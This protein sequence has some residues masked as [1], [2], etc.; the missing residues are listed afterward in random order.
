M[1]TILRLLATAGFVFAI[2]VGMLTLDV[3]R[4][5]DFV[6]PRTTV[7]D[8]SLGGMTKI[9][10]RAALKQRWEV[11]SQTPITLVARG[12]VQTFTLSELGVLFDDGALLE[13]IPSS[14]RVSTLN[15][16]VKG[17]FGRRYL[18]IVG[19]SRT[20][21]TELIYKKFPTIPE[22]KNA[23]VKLTK[24][25]L[26]A[27]DGVTGMKPV[28]EPL[29]R[30]LEK[31]I[32]FFEASPLIIKF[33][34][35]EPDISA[36]DLHE[37]LPAIQKHL[38]QKI[39]FTFEKQTVNLDLSKH[40]DWI[41]F[42][43]R[44]NRDTPSLANVT[45]S[46][47]VPFLMYVD[48]HEFNLFVD[49]KLAQVVDQKPEDVRIWKESNVYKV[50][51]RG[52][53]GRAV[54]RDML[55][56]KISQLLNNGGLET[57]EVPTVVVAAKVDITPELQDLGI[58]ELVAVGFTRYDGSPANRQHN[59]STGVAKYNGIFIPQGVE[60]S[61]DENIGPVDG[62]HG[63]LKEL[64]I[65]PEGTV[66]EFGGGLCQVSTTLYRAALYAGLPISKRSPH[67]Y[68]VGYYAQV[69]GHG[70]DA[71]VYPP[72]VDLKF[73]NDTP[74]PLLIQSY[75]EGTSAYFKL[76]GTKDNREVVMDGPY[77]SNQRSAPSAPV[78]V[79]DKNLK[80]GQRKQVEKAH[81]G[82]DALWYRTITK[83]PQVVKEEIKSHYKAVPNKFLVG[84]ADVAAKP[85]GDVNPFE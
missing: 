74:G 48:P 19:I 63:F 59:V 82:F 45:L 57:I 30:E 10:A 8:V 41:R 37:Y 46:N 55:H 33:N 64:V 3:Y 44:E 85:D 26:Q 50:E 1:D 27:V 72:N 53:D 83:G 49:Q 52:A 14:D 35:R 54:N 4:K 65:K 21:I 73:I 25:G 36:E 40:P 70:L 29:A 20:Q 32:A 38:D 71:T 12:E 47:D 84:G 24:N 17:L 60:F 9:Q 66:P 62:E 76:Y 78:E 18:P 5:H 11:L 7:G 61:F 34:E 75:T 23:S 15:L 13:R 67:S 2:F 79:P 56:E 42:E 16:V 58:K 69:G 28:V 43:R 6:L 80:P 39:S 51:G 81:N 77:I 31:N 68:A 22:A